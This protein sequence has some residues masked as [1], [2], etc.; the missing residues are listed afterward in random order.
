MVTIL[1]HHYPCHTEQQTKV[2]VLVKLRN[3]SSITRLC[4][5]LA[6]EWTVHVNSAM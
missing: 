6:S 4:F 3:T 2:H 1:V 5:V